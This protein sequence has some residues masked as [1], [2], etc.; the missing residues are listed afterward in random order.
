[1]SRTHRIAV[2]ATI[3]VLV[4][5]AWAKGPEPQPTLAPGTQINVRLK[6]KL[7]SNAAKPG[8]Q[9][10][11]RLETPITMNGQVLY[12]KGTE[13]GGYVVRSHAS[14]GGADPGVLELDL[15]S[16]GAGINMASL[17]AKTLVLK[18]E[19]HEKSKLAVM[20]AKP[21]SDKGKN[22]TLV[23]S[24]AVLTW[25]TV[26]PGGMQ[27]WSQNAPRGV[28]RGAGTPFR[29]IGHETEPEPKAVDTPTYTFA[30]PDRR[31]LRK[32]VAARQAGGGKVAPAV[33]RQ[34][35]KGGTLPPGLQKRVQPLPRVCAQ[36][37][38]PVPREWARVMFSGRV[39]LLDPGRRIVDVF[40]F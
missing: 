22:E 24:D 25:V 6:D 38:S 3:V 5:S 27:D 32:C 18:G 19:L 35:R 15:L 31:A 17:S 30:E 7:R 4:A 14:G 10:R 11:G 12:P 21:A 1:M 34:L 20:S 37:L 8:D 26:Q 39:M 29:I 23:E 2:L 33:E 36:Q 28:R 9:F 40:V 13:I 16:I